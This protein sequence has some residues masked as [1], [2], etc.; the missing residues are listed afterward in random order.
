MRLNE[1]PIERLA[2]SPAELAVAT[3]I[4]R[5]Q[6]YLLLNQRKIRA[7]KLGKRTI[8]LRA[9][10]EDFLGRLEEMVVVDPSQETDTERV[11]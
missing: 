6:I 9:D 2:Y 3:S 1:L 7:R 11:A 4:S 10:A 5:A 8:I